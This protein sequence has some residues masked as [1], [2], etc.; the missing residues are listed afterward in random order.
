[1][2]EPRLMGPAGG[3]GHYN[4]TVATEKF[5]VLQEPGRLYQKHSGAKLIFRKLAKATLLEGK[6]GSTSTGQ[7]W[8]YTEVVAIRRHPGRQC[9]DFVELEAEASERVCA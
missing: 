9:L 1:M 7:L 2:R 6:Q 4:S 5:T 8:D 3:G